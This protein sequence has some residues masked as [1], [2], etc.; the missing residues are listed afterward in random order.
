VGRRYQADHRDANE[1]AIVRALEAAGAS[2][3][4]LDAKD[5]APDLL[6]GYAATTFLQEVKRPTSSSGKTT[7]GASR[8]VNGGDGVSTRAQLDWRADWR[9]AP[10]AIVSTPAEALAAIG[11]GAGAGA[12]QLGDLRAAAIQ[13][14]LGRPA[15]IGAPPLP[16]RT[17][18]RP[19]ITSDEAKAI[20]ADP[21][22]T[23]LC[24]RMGHP[25]VVSTQVCACGHQLYPGV[26]V[27]AQP[28]KQRVKP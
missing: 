2:V 16:P 12:G 9:G 19:V 20:R 28:V 27:A 3:T 1:E 14:G 18:R 17:R 7:G 5:G 26:E 21:T 25:R 4:R 13:L 6:I 8:P 23:I 22:P 24:D 15:K 11:A 10:V